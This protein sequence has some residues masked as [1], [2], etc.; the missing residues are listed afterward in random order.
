MSRWL[1][2]AHVRAPPQTED[3]RSGARRCPRPASRGG[4]D[5]LR[6]LVPLMRLVAAPPQPGH[7]RRSGFRRRGRVYAGATIRAHFPAQDQRSIAT[8]AGALQARLAPRAEDEFGLDT[9]FADRARVVDLDAL[10]EGF[11]LERV[12]VQLGERLGW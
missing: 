3:E 10:Q 9:L 2:P 6:L 12:L 1:E 8:D 4:F 11:F 7:V 5:K